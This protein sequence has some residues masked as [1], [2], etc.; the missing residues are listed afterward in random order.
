MIEIQNVAKTFP[1]A[2]GDVTALADVNLTLENNEIICVLGPSGCG[3]STLLRILAGLSA[4]TRGEVKI[5]GEAVHG[6]GPG[7]AVVFQDYALFPWRTVRENIAFPLELHHVPRAEREARVAAQLSLVHLEKFADAYIH[8]LSGGMRQRVAIARALV[9]EPSVLLM[10]EPFGALD[11]FTRMSLQNEL[12]KIWRAK[13]PTI[14]FVTH[15]IDEAI[16]LGDRVVIMTPNPGKVH[17]V[18]DIPMGKPRQRT[19]AEFNQYRD[20]VYKE[21]SLVNDYE[22]EYYI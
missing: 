12:V 9:E 10:D 14:I 22:I 16:Y 21:F 3:K 19:S 11:A 18:I 1:Q 6:P 7:R 4:P 15:D 13:K 5:D 2:G 8:Q 17:A 20:K